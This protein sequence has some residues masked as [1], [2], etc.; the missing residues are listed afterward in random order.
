MGANK[1]Q[2]IFASRRHRIVE[3]A[4]RV[5]RGRLAIPPSFRFALFTVQRH[6]LC[7]SDTIA[8][9]TRLIVRIIVYP[10]YAAIV[11]YAA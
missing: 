2:L 3:L 11:F 10:Q 7:I 6:L 4:P 8:I 5:G 9:Y 1:K